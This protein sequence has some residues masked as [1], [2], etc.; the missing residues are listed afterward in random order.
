[1]NNK[2]LFDIQGKQ[3]KVGD[4]IIYFTKYNK[5]FF[6]KV[7]SFNNVM[8]QIEY[9]DYNRDKIVKK[10]VHSDKSLLLNNEVAYENI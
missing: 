3:L 5:A 8:T 10:Y 9:L 6:G 4:K 7:V 2:Q 1:M